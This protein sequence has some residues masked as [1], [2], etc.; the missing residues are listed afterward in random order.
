M[1]TTSWWREIHRK[2]L[3]GSVTAP[4]ELVEEV[5]I[6]LEEH[7]RF[8]F[9]SCR[10]NELISDAAT[11]AIINYITR[12][13][14]FDGK[15]RTLLGF[16]KMAAEG[17]FKN[18]SRKKSRPLEHEILTDPVELR[19]FPGNRENEAGLALDAAS[20][21]ERLDTLFP[22][23]IDRKLARLVIDGERSTRAFAILLGL[24]DRPVH[25]QRAEVKRHKDRIKKV[26]DRH[27][28]KQNE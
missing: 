14:T 2:L 13:A 22:S 25:E 9:P 28:K 23:E 7:L 15:S 6:P 27:G 17:D 20:A 5:L 11:D 19:L 26:L 1:K 16:L 24:A 4:A 10:D 12:P 3:E 18:L 8:I 21:N